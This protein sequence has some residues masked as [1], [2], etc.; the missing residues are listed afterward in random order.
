MGIKT[1]SSGL[2]LVLCVFMIAGCEVTRDQLAHIGKTPSMTHMTPPIERPSYKPVKWPEEEKKPTLANSLWQPGARTFFRDHRARRVGDILR[3]TI[4]IN[5]KAELDNETERKRDTDKSLNAPNLFGFE[6]EI[7]SKL[8]PDAA[9]PASLLSIGGANSH[10][11]TGAIAREEKINTEVAAMV[12]QILP[13]GNLVI[14]GSQEI[15]VNFEVREVSVEGIVRPQD[16]SAD[17]TIKS[18]QIAEARISYGGRGQLSD[19]Q[20]PSVG[21]QLIDVIS[22]F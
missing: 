6:G 22:P 18:T 16:I 14:S 13:N 21:S 5:D 20:Q 4:E 17:N 2:F 19:V 7:T 10:K 3:V 12:T 1:V 11:G 9:D 15:R 8:L